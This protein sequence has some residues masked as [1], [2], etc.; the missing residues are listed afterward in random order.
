MQSAK[1]IALPNTIVIRGAVWL[2]ISAWFRMLLLPP[3]WRHGGIISRKVATLMRR[4][5]SVSY[6]NSGGV[7]TLSL[8]LESI[9][10][11]PLLIGNLRSI[12]RPSFILGSYLFVYTSYLVSLND[13]TFSPHSTNMFS[14][15]S[16]INVLFTFSLTNQVRLPCF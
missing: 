6:C 13:V 4:N 2:K 16:S 8:L 14:Q 3:R 5:G 11:T 1:T 7:L 12:A 9:K 10:I 15:S